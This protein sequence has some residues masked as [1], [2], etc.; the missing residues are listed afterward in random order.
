MKTLAAASLTLF[1]VAA[2]PAAEIKIREVR[3]GL[4]HSPAIDSLKTTWGPDGQAIA[5]NESYLQGTTHTDELENKNPGWRI[6]LRESFGKIKSKGGLVLGLS[7]G[8]TE[9]QTSNGDLR[10]VPVFFSDGSGGYTQSDYPLYGPVTVTA[11]SFD[12]HLAYAIAPATWFHIETGLFVGGGS[13][14]VEDVLR[15]YKNDQDESRV[16]ALRSRGSGKWLEQGLE[17]SGVFTDKS[18]FQ[19][20]LTISYIRMEGE[21]TLHLEETAADAS[22]DSHGL[23]AELFAGFRF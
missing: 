15:Y 3:V 5:N 10:S 22:F 23:K 2:M 7:A 6:H 9:W 16:Q 17:F 14:A 1:A 8:Q 4:T 11:T 18:G 21:N 20:G 13:V 19:G 12:V